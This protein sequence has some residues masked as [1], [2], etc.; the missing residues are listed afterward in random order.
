[1]H[2]QAAVTSLHG[3]ILCTLCFF[4]M[5]SVVLVCPGVSPLACCDR[6]VRGQALLAKNFYI[7]HVSDAGE[8][9]K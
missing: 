7:M 5:L 1:M 8:G 4:L 3:L 6:H 9:T 2:D